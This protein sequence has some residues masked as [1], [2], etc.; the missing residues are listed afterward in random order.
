MEDIRKLAHIEIIESLTPIEGADKIETAIVLGWSCV[1]KRG[2][3]KVG[4]PIVYVE[5]DS[6]MPD[7]PEYEFLE[8]GSLELE[9]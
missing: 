9:L 5:V 1:V 2:E 6:V 8:I 3:F 4:Q 7:K